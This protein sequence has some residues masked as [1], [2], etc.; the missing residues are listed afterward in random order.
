MGK[1]NET[2]ADGPSG[3]QVSR[4]LAEAGSSP[5]ATGALLAAGG[6][7]RYGMPKVLAEDGAWLRRGVA[8]LREGGCEEVVVVLGAAVVEVPEPAS[9]VV[10]PDWRTGMAGSLRC[11]LRAARRGP[12][13]Q[14]I[15]HLVDIPD[16]TAEVV[17]RVRR[18]AG[19][20]G[21]A[22][23]AYDGVPG[24]PVAFGRRHWDALEATLTGDEGGRRFL[25]GREDV[26]LVPCGD[27]AGGGDHDVP[28]AGG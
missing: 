16:V 1:V 7:R 3:P 10:N 14:L 18:A 21:V 4:G 19:V 15:V 6:G 11:A 9:A 27:I 17:R 28:S 23:A 26:I 8:A 5:R 24:H 12:T 20:D 2:S 13:E 25:A 22:R